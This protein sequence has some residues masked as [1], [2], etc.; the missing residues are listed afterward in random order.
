MIVTMMIVIHDDD[1]GNWQRC[2]ELA[3][4]LQDA[5]ADEAALPSRNVRLANIHAV[6]TR[7]ADMRFRA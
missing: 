7:V 3:P 4:L 1:D 6:K 2:R 5:I